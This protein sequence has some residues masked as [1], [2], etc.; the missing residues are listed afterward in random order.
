MVTENQTVEKATNPQKEN[1]KSWLLSLTGEQLSMLRAGHTYRALQSYIRRTGWPNLFMGGL[2]FLLGIDG[3]GNPILKAIQA[4]LGLITVG[5][6]LWS[7]ISPMAVGAVGLAVW[8][9]L[10]GI[11]GLWN[12]FI[13]LYSQSL[14]VGALALLQLWWTYGWYLK[15][16]KHR[17]TSQVGGTDLHLY[18]D[19]RQAVARFNDSSNA[20]PDFIQVKIKDRIWQWFLLQG[21]AVLASRQSKLLMLADQSKTTFTFKVNKGLLATQ[22]LGTVDFDGV[23]EK[24]V[25]F[26]QVTVATYERWKGVSVAEKT[27]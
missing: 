9:I 4:L 5:V 1:I 24:H 16:Q 27:P 22:I 3:F 15:Y 2:T 20:D 26:P 8:G 14:I 11:A 21:R 13:A 25:I 19:L 6:S 7:L 18:D 10:M 12:V 23:S 17:Q